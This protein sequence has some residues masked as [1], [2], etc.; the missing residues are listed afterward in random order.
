[1]AKNNKKKKKK[2]LS[3]ANNKS[4]INLRYTFK[5]TETVDKETLTDNSI[6]PPQ[7]NDSKINSWF[8]SENRFWKDPNIKIAKIAWTLTVIGWS[9]SLLTTYAVQTGNKQQQEE[10]KNSETILRN[11]TKKEEQQNSPLSYTLDDSFKS[12]EKIGTTTSDASFAISGDGLRIKLLNNNG[13]FLSDIYI[14][15]EFVDD[16]TFLITRGK[17]REDIID[18]SF[19]YTTLKDLDDHDKYV[20]HYFS[21]TSGFNSFLEKKSYSEIDTSKN[22]IGLVYDEQTNTSSNYDKDFLLYFF[23]AKSL[24]LPIYKDI[25][26][27][28][29]IIQGYNKDY[30]ILT[31]LYRTGYSGRK[32][33][34]GTEDIAE[35]NSSKNFNAIKKNA[36]DELI[37]FQGIEIYD[38]EEWITQLKNLELDQADY[39]NKKNDT[40]KSYQNIIKFIE[41]NKLN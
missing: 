9:I 23:N 10:A 37:S 6:Q 29:L 40:I 39:L 35:S 25:Y 34:R 30:Q 4:T 28:H 21:S 7:K 19:D 2:Q 5:K 18:Y 31:F 12:T 38:D 8:K 15:S 32:K 3:Q 26:I 13:G 41:E 33:E 22:F 24:L 20:A 16:N 36:P 17:K 27:H 11:Q 1:M 14:T